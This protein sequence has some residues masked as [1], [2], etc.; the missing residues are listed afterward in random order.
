MFVLFFKVL[1][2]LKVKVSYYDSLKT[3]WHFYHCGHICCAK[4]SIIISLANKHSIAHINMNPDINH[5]FLSQKKSQVVYILITKQ[6]HELKYLFKSEYFYKT[7]H[8]QHSFDKLV[9]A[10]IHAHIQ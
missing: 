10:V 2:L 9:L 3:Y 5:T 8:H 7:I 1:L 4:Q 6:E